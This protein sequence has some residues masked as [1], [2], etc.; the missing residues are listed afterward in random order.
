MKY[1]RIPLKATI[2]KAG[3][4]LKLANEIGY[5]KA[6]VYQWLEEGKVYLPELAAWRYKYG[7]KQ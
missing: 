7:R 5:T 6:R 3:G 1:P 2:K 4:P